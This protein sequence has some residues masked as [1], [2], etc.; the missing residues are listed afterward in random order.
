MLSLIVGVVTMHSTVACHDATGHAEKAAAHLGGSPS[1]VHPFA[2]VLAAPA[3]MAAVDAHAAD[4]SLGHPMTTASTAAG[5]GVAPVMRGAD[6]TV[7]T[8]RPGQHSALH[9]LLHLC[10]AV[11]TA[12]IAFA[13]AALL[14]LLVGRATRRHASTTG[15]RPVAGPRAPPP[16]SVRLAQLCVLRN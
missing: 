7:G 6:S 1:T 12:L 4:S 8:D 3:A 13:A 14:A 10:L 5:A 15:G 9:D 16:T 2:A 11:L